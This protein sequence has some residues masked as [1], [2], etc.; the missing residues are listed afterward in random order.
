MILLLICLVCIGILFGILQSYFVALTYKALCVN[1]VTS[2]DVD[3]IL[4]RIECI[5]LVVKCITIV[6][7]LEITRVPPSALFVPQSYI[8]EYATVT[9]HQR[10][11]HPYKLE[12]FICL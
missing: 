6:S 1:Y 9:L 3:F 5:T 10:Y 12:I 4:L 11:A 2:A 8:H 7:V